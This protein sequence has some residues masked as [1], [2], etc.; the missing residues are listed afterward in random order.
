[1]QKGLPTG[2]DPFPKSKLEYILDRPY[3]RVLFN[4]Y[5]PLSLQINK[6][7]LALVICTL[8]APLFYFFLLCFC[9]CFSF[10]MMILLLL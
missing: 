9:F 6:Q 5:W 2:Q 7:I 1:M 8:G 4:I 10:F 3:E